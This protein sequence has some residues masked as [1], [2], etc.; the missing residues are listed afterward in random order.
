MFMFM[1]RYG[2]DSQARWRGT[3][4]LTRVRRRNYQLNCEALE[5]RQLL[6]AYYIVNEASG[7]VLDDPGF[8]TSNGADIDQWQL[9]GGA[10]QQWNVVPQTDGRF[11]LV[12]LS[13]SK[14]LTDPN[15][16]KSNGT[17]IQQSQPNGG[18]NQQWE[19]VQ[20]KD[21]NFELLNGYSGKALADPNS[22]TSNGTPVIQYQPD[23]GTEQQWTLL[24]V[25]KAPVVTNYVVNASSGK[26]LDDPNFSTS[27]GT[28]IQQYQLSLR[29]NQQWTFVPLANGNDLIVNASSG[30]VLDDPNF[31]TSNGTTVIQYQLNGGTNQQWKLVGQTDGNWEV[32]NASSGNVLADPNSSTSNG[33]AIRQYQPNGGTNQQW[34]ISP[35]ANPVAITAYSPASAGTPLFKNGGPSYLD[36]AQGTD[37][38]T[39]GDCW[40]E[41][42]LAEV[43]AQD[44]QDIRNMFTYDGTTVDNGATVG[45]YTVRF[46]NTSGSPVYVKVDTELPSGGDYYDHVRNDLGTQ[47]LWVALAEKAYAVANGL[48]YVTTANEYQDSYSALYGG[49]PSWALPAITGKPAGNYNIN[50]TNLA[51]DWNSGDLIE[52]VTSS[53][54]SSYLFPNHVYAM[55][56]YNA[57]SS[58]PF[59][60][61]NPWGTDSSGWCP[62]ES[63]KIY[64][65]FWV[66]ASFISQN[67]IKQSI[68]HG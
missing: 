59:E 55:V 2:R 57:A 56:G 6:S 24:A 61:F 64:G 28:Q 67:F 13:S 17:I 54:R 62:G 30:K 26:V 18:A 63:H 45:L 21:G 32:K 22:S 48:G 11:E 8:S 19:L 29:T 66:N 60:L 5:S 20:Q 27:N 38:S 7:K 33:T 58:E 16:S 44:P 31:S 35:F 37:P 1:Q 51:S 3:G 52:L 68:G 65:R 25:G 36:V 12:N 10:N 43:A 9:N 14:A 34:N 49:W 40:L 4:P 42:S 23:G 50:S 39:V 41:A 15:F 46:F 47:V 53:P